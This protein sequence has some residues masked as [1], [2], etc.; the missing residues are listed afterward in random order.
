[1]RFVFEAVDRSGLIVRGQIEAGGQAPAIEQLLLSGHTPLSLVPA[2][3]RKFSFAALLSYSRSRHDEFLVVVREL[4]S[5]V[6]AGLPVERAIGV[7]QGFASNK[8]TALRLGQVLTRLRDGEPLSRAMGAVIPPGAAHIGSL[9]AAGEASGHLPKI[10]ANLARNLER[11]KTLRNRLVSA[12]TY[13][14]F[15][16]MTLIAVLWVLF[17]SVLPRLAPTFAEAHAALPLPT[18]ILLQ[19]SDFLQTYWFALVAV[20]TLGAFSIAMAMRREAVRLSIDRFLL[21]SP[22]FLR[23]PL[24]YESAKFCRNLETLLSGGLPLDRALDASR[25]AATNRWF[26]DRMAA[27]QRE[28]EAGISLRSAFAQ[29]KVMPALVTEFAAVGE[30]TGNLAVMMGEGATVLE[31]DVE[32]R[33]DRLMALVL[34]ISTLFMGLIVAGVMAAIVTGL[35]AVNDL[36]I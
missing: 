3:D 31:G 18:F 24:E 1:V 25:A 10:M 12:L 6:K 19:I 2:T 7:M 35:L 15:L 36:A 21:A 34:P 22:I 29:S 14:A 32:V 13:P 23:V 30:E 16:V 26:R 5:L 28:V 33:L 8:A 20:L 4:A 27:A 9:L 11:A 17:A